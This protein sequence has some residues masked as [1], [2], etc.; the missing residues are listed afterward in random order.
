MKVVEVRPNTWVVLREFGS[1]TY[2][3]GKLTIS[4]LQKTTVRDIIKGVRRAELDEALR[5]DAGFLSHYGDT[6]VL[7]AAYEFT[8]KPDNGV[9]TV[10]WPVADYRNDVYE[11]GPDVYD[12]VKGLLES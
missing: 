11:V 2:V 5:S 9:L 3:G 8:Y 1:I 7:G 6:Y 12:R 10:I 4:R